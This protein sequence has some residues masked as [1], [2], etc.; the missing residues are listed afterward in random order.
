MRILSRFMLWL[1]KAMLKGVRPSDLRAKDWASLA[2]VVGD[3]VPP[4][5]KAELV[6][7]PSPSP[8]MIL[9]MA[10]L[11]ALIQP[12]VEK[13]VNEFFSEDE[14]QEDDDDGIYDWVE[15]EPVKMLN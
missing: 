2:L 15:K 7:I 3:K 13:H 14:E 5:W 6:M 12:L 9:E 1:T 8:E 11:V 10:P 4:N